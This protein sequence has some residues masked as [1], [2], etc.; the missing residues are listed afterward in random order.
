MSEHKSVLHSLEIIPFPKWKDQMKAYFRMLGLRMY[1]DSSITPPTEPTALRTYNTEMDKAAGLLA[2]YLGHRYQTQ[3][4]S[5]EIKGNPRAIWKALEDHFEAKTGENQ[6]RVVQEFLTIKFK[7][8]DVE[9]FLVDLDTHLHDI[10]AVGIKI[11]KTDEF[12]L[13]ETFVSEF[14]LSKIPTALNIRELLLTQCP[15]SIQKLRDLLEG[16]R[17][18][19]APSTSSAISPAPV[20]KQE[21]ALAANSSKKPGTF[22]FC[23]PGKHN[24]ATKHSE[25]ECRSLKKGKPTAKTAATQSPASDEEDDDSKSIST[26]NSGLVCIRKALSAVQSPDMC[27]L[28]SGASHHMFSDKGCF[29]GYRERTT[30]ISLADGNT[31]ESVGEGYVHILASDGSSLK[32]KALHVPGLAGSLISFGCLYERNCDLVRTGLKTFNIVRKNSILLSAAVFN[33]VCNVKLSPS[34]EGQSSPGAANVATT[35][36]IESLHRSAGHPNLKALKKM[37]PNIR[38]A[39]INCDACFLSKSHRLPFPGSLPTATQPLEYIYM[40]LSGRIN[41]PSF[42][43]KEYYFKITDYYS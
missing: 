22:P 17:R 3:F 24:P 19:M 35:T 16:K 32:L 6:S 36:N 23:S 39:K 15:L 38:T 28:D 7:G 12:T 34:S 37:F 5:T 25:E 42:G 18:D 26:T 11:I 41:P 10:S 20:I 27:F 40:D 9:S 21:S 29:T 30:S 4:V 1:I 8:T 13:H 14:L 43:G 33:G 2:M 31:L